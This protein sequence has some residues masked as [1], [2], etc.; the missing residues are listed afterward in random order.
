MKNLSA[1]EIWSVV[2]NNNESNSLNNYAVS[3]D[4]LATALQ[5][6]ASALMEAGNNLEQ[7]VALVA[8]ANKVVQD[9]SSVGSALRTISLRLRG[10]SVS[11]LEELG[12]ETDGTVESVSKMQEKI[13]ALTG[14]NILTDS[15]AYKDTYTILNEIGQVWEDMSDIDQA[16]LLELMAGKNRANTLAAILGNMEDLEG[17][18]K[19]A[20]NAEG[21]ALK[22]NA[23]YLDSIQGRI[24]L[25]NN[26]L[27]TMWMNF[28]DDD[29]VKRIV[30]LGT[31]LIK[32]IDLVNPLNV[33]LASLFGGMFAKYSMKKNNTNI[34]SLLFE[35]I[36][37]KIKNT[38]VIQNFVSS[39][40]T[41]YASAI[42]DAFG[43]VSSMDLLAEAANFDD[44]NNALGDLANIFGDSNITK[45]QAKEV[46]D[47]FDDISDATKEAILNSNLF[48]VSQT[49]AAAGTNIFT[50]SL[51]KAKAG[52][53]AF[54]KGL[55]TFATAH[56]IIAGLTVAVIALGAAFGIYKKFGPT[57]ENYIKKLEEETENLKSVQSELKS[58]QSEL[59]KTNKRM[60]E[61]NSK[62]TLSFVEEEELNRLKQ[63]T[64]ELERQEEILLAQ[65]KRARNKQIETALNAAKT[66]KNLSKTPTNTTIVEQDV[67]TSQFTGKPSYAAVEQDAATSQFTG[68]AQYVAD[69]QTGANKYEST[70][71]ALKTAKEDL[72]KAETELA[73]T[74]Y[75]AES[76]EYKKLEKA[77]EKAQGRVDKYNN[78]IDSMDEAWQTEYGEVGYIEN[79][80]TEAEKK[81]NEFYR[82]HQDYLDQ[83]ALINNTYG[84]STV[85]DRVFGEKG[86]DIA[87][88]FKEQFESSIKEGKSPAKVIEELLASENFSSTLNDLNNKFG[89]TADDI[90]GYFTRI[91]EVIKAQSGINSV[92]TYSTLVTSLESYNE[93]LAQTSEMVFD[94]IEVT[95]EYKDS[96]TALGIS[97]EE[98]AECF[99]EENKL[100]VTNSEQ[101]N[102][103]VKSAK[104][105]IAQNAKLAKSQARL[106]YYELYK[107]MKDLTNG[108]KIESAATLNQVNAIYEEMSALEKTIAKYTLLEQK[109]LGATNAYDKLADAQAVDEATD[110]GSKAEE[111]VNVLA[112]AFNTSEL[113]TEAAQVAIRGLVPDEVIDKTKTL[114]EQMQQ[115]YSYFTKG[116]M[117]QLF[118]I[119]FDDDGGITSVEMM[120]ED[121]EAF[122]KSLI[123]SA[124]DGAVFQGTWDEFTL[125]PAIQTL[126]D[127][128]RECGLTEEVAF[129]FL[130]SLEKYDI[131]WL[132]GDN[133]T[134]LDQL[135]GHDFE[136]QAQKNIQALA[137]L[138]H[139]MANGKITAEEYATK[140]AEL[141]AVQDENNKK[142]RENTTEWASVSTGVNNAKQRVEELTREINSMRES[143][144]SEEE[145]QV[146]T[147]QLKYASTVLTEALQKKYKL[148]EPTA[149]TIQI[150]LDE[151]NKEIEQFKAENSV[152]LTKVQVV[153]DE[154]GKHSYTVNAG[155]NLSNEEKA[156]V[157]TY[158]QALNDQYTITVL[159]DSDP[160]DSTTELKEVESAA[161]AAQEAV[162]NIPDPEIDTTNAQNAIKNLTGT[163]QN[164]INTLGKIPEEVT[165]T[166]TQTT[167]VSTTTSG[168]GIANG[169]A[170]V[171][172]TA[173]KSGS[174]GAPKTE[175][176][177]MGELGSEL[178]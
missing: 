107:E 76:K 128:A 166:V 51:A 90:V 154:N 101:L 87:K 116:A 140:Y 25:F 62:G 5:D 89:I 3:S 155:V 134:L 24:D 9:P 14:V 143:G 57:H 138:E 32:V 69:Q 109:L 142:I 49:G 105:N 48:A 55:M 125:N 53:I 44:A 152:L 98:L 18:Y 123:G 97:S 160:N 79:A 20:L 178:V 82:Q 96:L 106:K 1:I 71:N 70:L 141:S 86:T 164:L 136:Y 47:S 23:A 174:W 19:D 172:G 2:V 169:T 94:N 173:Y 10:T 7:S 80:T 15:G 121:V 137:D 110:Y 167:V 93:I 72:E 35:T 99:D 108:R 16:A 159:A 149:M 61:L 65:E 52:L 147:T 68:G 17:A 8:S 45:Q 111:M 162:E 59:E 126:E 113:G 84:K 78:T 114:D 139:Q 146:K 118:T 133:E 131:N 21:S 40:K 91:G 158:I 150:A 60:D 151:A 54:G 127:F 145:I 103:L 30:D 177:L 83:Q 4:G 34:L 85:L 38:P 120:K 74:T 129:A 36:P 88:G 13:E 163:V 33:A 29:V 112:E 58:V 42:G 117:S 171:H 67:A 73:S 92:Q 161:E 102:K 115:I 46:L 135:M 81:W 148:Q 50:A 170:H 12:E 37:T 27:Q 28:I 153:Q 22:E 31:A 165:T 41:A 104:S 43:T 56:P 132:G 156:K 157:D 75:D 11:V 175:T 64:A 66:D 77:V 168:P 144:A 95:Q 124:E 6:S 63:Q 130:T 176:A 119:E 100:I 26:S 39:V 122:T